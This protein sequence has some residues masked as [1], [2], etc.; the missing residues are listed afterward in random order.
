MENSTIKPKAD[1]VTENAANNGNEQN[2]QTKSVAFRKKA[3]I[4]YD[5]VLMLIAFAGVIAAC[6]E[7][8]MDSMLSILKFIFP[9]FMYCWVI[10]DRV[11]DIIKQIN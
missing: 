5:I 1:S 6:M 2:Q 8:D 4:I 3:K 10:I 11:V 7:L 9:M